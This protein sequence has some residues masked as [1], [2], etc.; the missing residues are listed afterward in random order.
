[1][2]AEAAMTQSASRDKIVED[3]RDRLAELSGSLSAIIERAELAH[4]RPLVMARTLGVDKN[5]TWKVARLAKAKDLSE[6]FQHL[7]GEAGFEILLQALLQHGASRPSI[8]RARRAF[9]AVEHVVEEH[10]G[11]RQTL[12][13]LLD[14]VDDK[15]NDRLLVS[16]KLAFRGNSGIWGVQARTR[17]NTAIVMP[18]ATNAEMIDLVAIGGWIDFLRTRSD[19]QWTLFRRTM[20][21]D[22]DPAAVARFQ[23]ID[24]NEPRDGPMLIRPFCTESMPPIEV[25]REPNNVIVHTLAPSAVGKTGAFNCFYGSVL[26]GIGERYASKDDDHGEVG[27]VVAAPVE[28]LQFDLLVHR[29]LGF[30]HGA[31]A[32][33]YGSTSSAERRERD[34]LPLSV[35]RTAPVVAGGAIGASAALVSPSMTRYRELLDWVAG[36]LRIDLAEF[37][38]VRFTLDYPPYPSTVVVKFPL[39]RRA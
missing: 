39:A 2:N 26:R 11:D 9:K 32:S 35:S 36:Q 24:P 4:Q 28:Q 38:A 13:I 14:G 5:I 33:V 18:G 12:E 29:S 22:S 17:I 21:A 16:R 1:M 8:D 3:I 7:P 23:P 20:A 10:A 27:A 30:E 37:N 6:A 31:R 34:L 15:S 25:L 19:A